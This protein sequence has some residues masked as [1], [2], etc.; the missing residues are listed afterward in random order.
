MI[1]PIHIRH[2]LIYFLE[3][4]RCQ[5]IS[6][7]CFTSSAYL[8][9]PRATAALLAARRS[10]IGLRIAPLA[11]VMATVL[12]AMLPIIASRLRLA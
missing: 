4:D 12:P 5:R 11:P 2:R 7:R 3:F 9:P 1:T 8:Q 10:G 6:V